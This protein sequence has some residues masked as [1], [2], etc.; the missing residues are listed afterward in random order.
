MYATSDHALRHQ[1]ASDLLEQKLQA[2]VSA[3]M[4]AAK[5][6]GSF[7][8]ALTTEPSLQPICSFFK[9]LLVLQG[10]DGIARYFRFHFSEV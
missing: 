2:V 3:H 8:A 6:I 9:W 10:S 7:R 5:Q 4:G 1:K